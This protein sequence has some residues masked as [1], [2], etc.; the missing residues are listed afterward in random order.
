MR[1]CRFWAAWRTGKPRPS[2]AA[3]HTHDSIHNSFPNSETKP[4]LHLDF[5]KW[6]LPERRGR[7]GNTG[8]EW[9]RR[10]PN[11]MAPDCRGAG[12]RLR[13][14]PSRTEW[15]WRLL[16]ARGC[17]SSVRFSQV[18][19]PIIIGEASTDRGAIREG[20]FPGIPRSEV[21][22]NVGLVGSLL[23]PT[24]LDAAPSRGIDC[25][26]FCAT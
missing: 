4:L 20:P 17:R 21:R 10:A 7:H 3:G 5:M 11:P 19:I 9:C 2:S 16:T 22:C 13:H 15:T 24:F 12:A 25:E 23:T 26:R 14:K 1:V 8:S 6:R 18:P